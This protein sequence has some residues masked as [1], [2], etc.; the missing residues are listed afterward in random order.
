MEWFDVE[1]IATLFG[2]APRTVRGWIKQGKLTAVRRPFGFIDPATK[3]YAHGNKY[4]IP[5]VYL[6]EF[7]IRRWDA[8]PTDGARRRLTLEELIH[9]AQLS[10][11]IKVT[12]AQELPPE[13]DRVT[14]GVKLLQDRVKAKA[15]RKERLLIGA[16]LRRLL[17]PKRPAP[18]QLSLF[19]LESYTHDAYK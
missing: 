12:V 18:V 11:D 16:P 9:A 8:A 13:F 2:V 14:Q 10:G 15:Q 4:F 3:K 19:D 6:E 17:E 5:R 1:S 7:L